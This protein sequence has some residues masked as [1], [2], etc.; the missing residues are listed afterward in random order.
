MLTLVRS[1]QGMKKIVQCCYHNTNVKAMNVAQLNLLPISV[2]TYM[3]YECQTAE[4]NRKRALLFKTRSVPKLFCNSSLSIF[5]SFKRLVVNLII[6]SKPGYPK[7]TSGKG[8]NRGSRAALT[9]SYFVVNDNI[10][11]ARTDKKRR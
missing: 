3:T 2:T 1:Q 9:S 11:M 10:V 7:G 8:E 6:G 4:S 5:R